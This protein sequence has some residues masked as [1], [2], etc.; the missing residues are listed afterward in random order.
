MNPR[1]ASTYLTLPSP[2]TSSISLS[3]ELSQ[4]IITLNSQI[5]KP[6]SEDYERA[7]ALMFLKVTGSG[8]G[9]TSFGI[10]HS[11]PVLTDIAQGLVAN[12]SLGLITALLQY[13]ADVRIARRRSTN[14][15]KRMVSKDQVNIP[16]N[17]VELA[18]RNCSE[19][20]VFLLAQTADERCVTEA[21]PVAISQNDAA[22]AYILL[23]RGADASRACDQF[24]Q[25]V[26]SGSDDMV[27][28]LL[29]KSKGACQDCRNQGLV[30]AAKHGH[31]AKAQMLLANG[32]DVAFQTGSALFTACK[33]KNEEVAKHIAAHETMSGRTKLLDDVVG[34]AYGLM[35]DQLIKACLLA[36]A[37]G[38]KTD[39]T[40]LKAVEDQNPPL[41][42]SLV[43]H[44][45]SVCYENGAPL[46]SAVKA[47][48]PDLLKILLQGKPS[49]GMLYA[50]LDQAVEIPDLPTVRQLVEL[51]LS[52]GLRGDTVAATLLRVLEDALIMGNEP[53]DKQLVDILL[54]KGSA[55]V[56]YGGGKLF[57]LA[58]GKKR[59]ELLSTFLL[60]G[61]SVV[62]LSSAA[63]AAM[64]LNE[65][66]IRL[67]VIELLMQAGSSQTASGWGCD[68]RLQNAVAI[69]AAKGLLLD[70]LQYLAQR[71]TSTKAFAAAFAAL[72]SGS[73]NWL[74][75]SGLEVIQ[76]LLELGASGPEID[77]AFCRAATR[78]DPDAIALLQSA[79]GPDALGKALSR[80]MEHSDEWQFPDNLWLVSDL[81]E[82]GCAGESVNVALLKA[83]TSYVNGKGTEDL[84]DI[85]LSVGE[86]ADVNFRD[87]EAL[88]IAIRA[89]L[90]PLLEKLISSGAKSEA[91][92]Q[93]FA[94]AITAPLEESKVLALIEVLVNHGAEAQCD[95]KAAFRDG[96]ELG[97]DLETPF[98]AN[99]SDDKT[100]GEE[101][102]TTLLWALHRRDNHRISST[103]IVELI[104]AKADLHFTSSVSKTTCLILAAKNGR[105]DIVAKLIAEKADPL[106]TDYFAN[107]ALFYASQVG[108]VE[109]AKELIKAHSRLNDGSLHEAARNLHVKVV[110]ALIKGKHDPGFP[111]GKHHGRSA[112]QE[113]TA[114]C[115]GTREIVDIEGTI[116]ALEKGAEKGKSNALTKHRATG[117]NALF[118][119]LGNLNPCHVTEA[120]LHVIWRDLNNEE[121]VFVTSNDTMTGDRFCYSPTMYLRKNCEGTE[122]D[123]DN[124]GKLLKILYDKQ[125]P[126]RFYILFGSANLR[127]RQPHDAIGMPQKIDDDETR[128]RK[129]DEKYYTKEMEH[130]TKLQFEL[131]EAATKMDIE[132][133]RQE[134]KQNYSHMAH[135]S[136]L[137]QHG[138][139][140][141]QQLQAQQQKA[142]QQLQAQQQRQSL[143][144][145]GYEQAEES[146][147]RQAHISAARTQYEHKQKLQFQQQ[148][149]EQSLLIQ[150][151]KGKQTIA[152]QQ[153]KDKLARKANADKVSIEQKKAKIQVSTEQKKTQ[154]QKKKND[155]TVSMQQDKN[156]LAR[157]ATAD[158]LSGEKDRDQ[159]QRKKN[160]QTL[161][162]QQEKNWLTREAQTDKLAADFVGAEIKRGSY[163]QGY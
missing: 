119:A 76:F 127:G 49:D 147:I 92:T 51:I 101:Q 14:L 110:A 81:L 50:A 78:F 156:K 25:A 20:V 10:K 9:S 155:Q 2:T 114:M 74:N 96:L 124:D 61:P 104:D 1:R 77:E 66:E 35:Q 75:P 99:I 40:L 86:P 13:G 149:G 106:H 70:V 145:L 143:T 48:R 130:K 34:E 135:Q 85:L 138:Q 128:R 4:R 112:L 109:S 95:F 43:Q 60:H 31:V 33:N 68:E 65:P 47:G 117:K 26:Q 41:V 73:E 21:L 52:A 94:T 82:E 134:Q 126:D 36:G 163:R 98:H 144:V 118:M 120:L 53:V 39:A 58:I 150:Q 32:A 142:Q 89:G 139:L 27:N 56:N 154:I 5:I 137:V 55:N 100:I 121:N 108:D 102:V 123:P 151:Q 62:S 140:T 22:K 54:T 8:R 63:I 161:L 116:T 45:A 11:N 59:V 57:A 24:L 141:Q 107:A 17:V 105:A 30:R 80:V 146:K 133:Q 90:A 79:T 23:A 148:T 29:R 159:L 71:Q 7:N 84:I 113:L 42:E 131:E 69:A 153:E 103:T 64:T 115:D 67:Q 162:F 152:I 15:F 18:T 6:T 136:Q 122:P 12:P 111:S 3:L 93:A 87:G 158:R 44:G 129:E 19:D 72:V 28:I 157:R 16:N 125:C 97:C 37:K 132:A 83:A 88:K 38:L 46:L 91:L 160:A